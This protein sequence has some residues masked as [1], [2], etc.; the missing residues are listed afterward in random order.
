[1]KE[2]QGERGRG[3]EEERGSR[4]VY[5]GSAGKGAQ[6]LTNNAA[7]LLTHAAISNTTLLPTPG[8]F[9]DLAD[10]KGILVWQETMFACASYPRDP[11]FMAEVRAEV[12]QQIRRIS[13][14]PSVVIW[15]GNNEIETSL[16]WYRETQNNVALFAHD[17]VELFVNLI[18]GL[19]KEVR[20]AAL[21]DA[22]CGSV[23]VC[24]CVVC[25]CVDMWCMCCV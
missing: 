17:Y 19:M 8:L 11:G 24:V 4:C 18:G 6:S 14:H 21:W 5:G 9:Y 13:W 1:M 3:G 2:G 7:L 22:C 23:C 12:E 20:G 25:V 10:E 16:E 15:G